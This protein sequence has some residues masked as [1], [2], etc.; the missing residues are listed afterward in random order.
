MQPADIFESENLGT[1]AVHY[2]A[3]TVLATMANLLR[4]GAE[5]KKY[6]AAA[7]KI[8]EGINHYLW[9]PSKGYYG[10]YLYGKNY[11]ILSPRA[12]SLGEVALHIV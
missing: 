8:K 11:K 1:N 2:Q 7:Q 5:A 3:N 4:K 10:Q 9:L 12:E 6:K